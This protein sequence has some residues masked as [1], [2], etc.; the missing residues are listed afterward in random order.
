MVNNRLIEE[1]R[2]LARFDKVFIL[3]FI[4]GTSVA[5]EIHQTKDSEFGRQQTRSSTT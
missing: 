4:T 1:R 3:I 5:R 2:S